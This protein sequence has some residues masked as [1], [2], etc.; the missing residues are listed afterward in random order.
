MR[1]RAA[2]I[3]AAIL[4][5]I[6]RRAPFGKPSIERLAARLAPTL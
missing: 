2:A 1:G 3:L 4:R 6:A 5:E